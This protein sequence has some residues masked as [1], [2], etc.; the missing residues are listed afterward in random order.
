MMLRRLITLLL[1][2]LS[3][4]AYPL[5]VQAETHL[6]QEKPGQVT[7]RSQQSLQDQ[8]KRSWQTI[9]FKRYVDNQ[10]EGIFLRLVGFPGQ[11]EVAP[12]QPLQLSIAD[13]FL[14]QSQPAMDGTT[15]M[16]PENVG[17][18]NVQPLLE[19]LDSDTRLVLEIPLVSG[20]TANIIA[21]PAVI[22]EWREVTQFSPHS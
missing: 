22:H 6:Y 10:L 4:T 21:P 3:L 2:L 19:N 7:L 16:L 9:L 20:L 14:W 5:P 13:Q 18:Y 11:V 17:Q 8:A 12:E 15:L 1:L